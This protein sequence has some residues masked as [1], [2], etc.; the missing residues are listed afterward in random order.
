M[1]QRKHSRF[2]QF[3]A[4]TWFSW[5]VIIWWKMIRPNIDQDWSVET[6]TL[7][8]VDYRSTSIN[9]WPT[10][11]Y[12]SIPDQ[13]KMMFTVTRSSLI[14]NHIKSQSLLNQSS[15]L[16]LFRFLLST[17]PLLHCLSYL[18]YF[19][20]SFNASE[21]PCACLAT[22]LHRIPMEKTSS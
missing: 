3:F 12:Y 5:D 8:G 16:T 20:A 2:D 4:V 15:S 14:Q 6:L 11:V 18:T 21:T 17:G 10:L 13:F 19:S 22:F 9:N 1:S 7:G